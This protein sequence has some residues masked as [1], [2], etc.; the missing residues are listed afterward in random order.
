VKPP[1]GAHPPD[2]TLP[3]ELIIAP[4]EIFFRVSCS[5]QLGQAGIWSASEKRTILSKDSPHL[6]QVYSYKGIYCSFFYILPPSIP[7]KQKRPDPFIG[8]GPEDIFQ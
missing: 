1:P 2:E 5:P 6:L 8:P 4:A 7:Q 3:L